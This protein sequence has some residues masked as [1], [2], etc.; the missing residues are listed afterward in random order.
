[1]ASDL[2]EA[3]DILVEFP[4]IGTRVENTKYPE[5]RR[6]LLQRV[7]R[8]IYYRPRGRF[9]EVVAFWGATRERTPS[10]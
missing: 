1:V 7:G 5:T 8:H 9:L 10:M 2:K 4:C 3:L 6:W